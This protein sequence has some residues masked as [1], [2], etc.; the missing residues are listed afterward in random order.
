MSF[1]RIPLDYQ[2]R[3][4]LRTWGQRPPGL[5][6]AGDRPDQW[7]RARPDQGPASFA[8]FLKP[9]GSTVLR[10]MPDG[11]WLHFGGSFA[12]PYVDIFGI[13]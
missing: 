2:V 12:E 6:G 10:T 3:N 1:A 8:P 4:T 9:P 5:V 7:L 11:L 13:M